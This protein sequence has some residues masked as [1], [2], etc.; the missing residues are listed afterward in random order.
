M[1]ENKKGFLLY[2]DYIHTLEHLPDEVAGQLFKHILAY[3]NDQDPQTDNPLIK[4]AFE[5]IRQQL[6][7]DLVK[8][9][10]KRAT[11]SEAGIKGN[12]KKWHPVI[13]DQVIKGDITIE[14]ATKVIANDR[15]VSQT[16]A[17]VAVNVNGNVNGNVNDNVKEIIKTKRT[18]KK[19][20]Q[21]T[22]V[23]LKD[24]YISKGLDAPTATDKAEAFLNHYNS[25]GWKVGKNPMKSW[26]AAAAGVWMKDQGA[27]PGAKPTNNRPEADG[28]PP[29]PDLTWYKHFSRQPQELVQAAQKWYKKGYVAK[30]NRVTGTVESYIL[31]S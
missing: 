7:R 12:L 13:Y 14:E 28:I 21:P 29:L 20:V 3:V 10:G 17:N 25:N 26:E 8:Y 11:R 19:F 22:P 15:K 6:K 18:N 1:A 27:G 9:E 24:F 31:K 2:A 5:P 4:L 16:V 30:K 23:E